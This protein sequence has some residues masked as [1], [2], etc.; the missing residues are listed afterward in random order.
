LARH[1]PDDAAIGMMLI[2]IMLIGILWTR[3]QARQGRS[4]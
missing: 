1:A 4:R 2:R 3:H